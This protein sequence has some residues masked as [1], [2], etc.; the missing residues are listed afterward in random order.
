MCVCVMGVKFGLGS[1]LEEGI[2]RACSARRRSARKATVLT[3]I[4][5]AKQGGGS[6][7]VFSYFFQY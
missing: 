1:S 3:I 6:W 5:H 2:S 4:V 7:S